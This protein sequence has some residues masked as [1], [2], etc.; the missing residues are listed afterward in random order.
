[1]RHDW[2]GNVRELGNTVERAVI[3]AREGWLEEVHLPPALTRQSRRA[4]DGLTL[5]RNATI[6]EAERLMILD[7]LERVE[8][9]KAEAARRL[10]V[11]VKTIRNKLRQF[12]DGDADG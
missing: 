10:G 11:D 6:A 5:P 8:H 9:N 3:L 1:V 4:A 12:R 2:P 7:T